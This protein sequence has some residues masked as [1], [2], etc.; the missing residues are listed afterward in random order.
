[1]RGGG[2]EEYML[3]LLERIFINIISIQE[4]QTIEVNTE[5]RETAENIIER[6]KII[7]E[8][9]SIKKK[10]DEAEEA[11]RK[12]KFDAEKKREAEVKAWNDQADEQEKAAAAKKAG[13]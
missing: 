9:K 4:K 6:K 7:A 13:K 3:N 1:M 2:N 5:D 12:I 10:E 8:N 11:A